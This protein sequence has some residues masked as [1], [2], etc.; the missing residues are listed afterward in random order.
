MNHIRLAAAAIGVVVL[1]LAGPLPRASAQNN[2]PIAFPLSLETAEGTLVSFNLPASDPDG[3]AL[4]YS[5]TVGPTHGVVIVQG[6]TGAGNYTP[7]PGYCGP[8][9]FK[10]KVSDGQCTSADA[11]VTIIVCVR[12]SD[13][14]GIPD[15]ADECLGTPAGEVV[16]ASGCSIGQLCPCENDW[17]N[18]GGYVSCV[19]HISEAFVAEGLITEDE[20]DAI[21]SQA[22]RSSCGKR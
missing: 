5:L 18:H 16:N 19:A 20:K 11:T 10:F 14:D 17:E 3:D 22:A 9:S 15:N 6:A 7:N 2:C 8:D 4:Q 13:D 12:D 1:G 21:V